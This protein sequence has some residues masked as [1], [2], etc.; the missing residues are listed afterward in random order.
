MSRQLKTR[1][2]SLSDPLTWRYLCKREA[3]HTY[4]VGISEFQVQSDTQTVIVKEAVGQPCVPVSPSDPGAR[5]SFWKAAYMWL[6]ALDFL[7]VAGY[8]HGRVCATNCYTDIGLGERHEPSSGYKAPEHSFGSSATTTTTAGD[9]WAIGTVLFYMLTGVADP[10]KHMSTWVDVFGPVFPVDWQKKHWGKVRYPYAS[11]KE[12]STCQSAIDH[13]KSSMDIQQPELDMIGRLWAW[14]PEDRWTAT[15]CLETFVRSRVTKEFWASGRGSWD[16]PPH[17]VIPKWN[18]ADRA[19]RQQLLSQVWSDVDSNYFTSTPCVL[20]AIYLWDRLHDRMVDFGLMYELAHL[21]T[22]NRWPQHGPT[23]DRKLTK[24]HL[25]LLAR[26][27]YKWFPHVLLPYTSPPIKPTDL[28]SA[29]NTQSFP[30]HSKHKLFTSFSSLD[31][32]VT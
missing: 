28:R 32:S 24:D 7:H 10:F 11:D 21:F 23:V 16:T 12:C 26:L 18:K 13:Y 25:D 29:L 14:N 3:Y 6:S 17:P 27:D 1:V 15:Q 9:M 19:F 5:V 30:F 4:L 31:P 22:F 8:V 20:L 2:W